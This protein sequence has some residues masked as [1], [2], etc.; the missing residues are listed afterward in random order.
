MNEAVLSP[1]GTDQDDDLGR[2]ADI[3]AWVF[4]LDD[5][6]YTISPELAAEFD[7]RMRAFIEREI[8]VA[9]DEAG[10]LQ[11]D[12]FHRHGATAR[13]LMI[14]YGISP[15]DFLDY[16]HDVDHQTITPD[17]V[18]SEAIALLPGR[19]YVLT[20]GPRRHAEQTIKQIGADGHFSEIFDFVRAGRHAKPNPE[21]YAGLIAE[22]GAAPARMAMFEDMVRNLK[23][24]KRLGMTTILV[25]PPRTRDLFR[26]DWD[27]EAGPDL[28]VDFVTEDLGGF[29]TAIISE[30]SASN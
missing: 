13:G 21:V 9:P 1:I 17:P 20:N 26:G 7:G 18:L 24:P 27:V 12:L 10:R 23:E 15:D 30:I 4:D 8:G 29:L 22:T 2:F 14:E 16:V 3:D 28:E 6:L 25:V 11:H 19:R 5:T